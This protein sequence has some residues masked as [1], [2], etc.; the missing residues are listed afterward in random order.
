[1]KNILITLLIISFWLNGYFIYNNINNKESEIKTELESNTEIVN[2]D[3]DEYSMTISWIW[4]A[5]SREVTVVGDQKYWQE[6]FPLPNDFKESIWIQF[7]WWGDILF[8]NCP[9]WYNMESC[10]I[11]EGDN[12]NNFLQDSEL[13]RCWIINE[14]P[15][16]LRIS[17]QMTCKRV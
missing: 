8:A 6:H 11:F 17:M 14:D 9:E 12:I 16:L 10:N 1:M 13:W 3:A 5:L 2:L 4:G 15:N 7:N